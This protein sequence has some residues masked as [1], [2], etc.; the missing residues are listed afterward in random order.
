MSIQMSIQ[1]IP[2]TAPKKSFPHFDNVQLRKIESDINLLERIQDKNSEVRALIC[3]KKYTLLSH[4]Y[5]IKK[6][7]VTNLEK[8]KIELENTNG[9]L[10][11]K[12]ECLESVIGEN[13]KLHQAKKVAY[14]SKIKELEQTVSQKENEK[15]QIIKGMAKVHE[16]SKMFCEKGT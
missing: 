13:N 8:E 1:A 5:G 4:H 2:Y 16:L 12:V 11:R 3:E 7:K 14:E 6:N 10:K 15:M 9:G